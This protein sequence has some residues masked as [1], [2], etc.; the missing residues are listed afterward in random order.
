[1]TKSSN[2]SKE[3]KGRKVVN[4]LLTHSPESECQESSGKVYVWYTSLLCVLLCAAAVC[5]YSVYHILYTLHVAHSTAA[6]RTVDKAAKSQGLSSTLELSSFSVA[7]DLPSD[8]RP[9]LTI[10]SWP[11]GSSL[12]ATHLATTNPVSPSHYYCSTPSSLDPERL[13][14]K[15]EAQKTSKY[16]TLAEA[17][18]GEFDPL[19]V[20]S[21]VVA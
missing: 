7:S 12:K 13:L 18:G 5:V 1:M 6:L 2:S 9:D 11:A 21:H 15:R 3:E 8:R 14:K 19:A 10:T 4:Y 17:Q 16:R 20:G